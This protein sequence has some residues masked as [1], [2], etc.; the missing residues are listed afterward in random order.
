MRICITLLCYFYTS[1]LERMYELNLVHLTVFICSL[2]PQF[3]ICEPE[4]AISIA[5]RDL[6]YTIEYRPTISKRKVSYVQLILEAEDFMC[7]GI[8]L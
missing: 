1:F 8:P 3:P 7:V 5:C 4:D 6:S 2:Q